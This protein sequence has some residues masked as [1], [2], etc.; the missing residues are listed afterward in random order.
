MK[1]ILLKIVSIIIT[2]VV[3]MS[4]VSILNISGSGTLIVWIALAGTIAAVG[5][6]WG[7]QPK[8]NGMD[9]KKDD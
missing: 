8:S 5:A 6:I 2:L 4:I 9:L 1:G 3:G 7:Y